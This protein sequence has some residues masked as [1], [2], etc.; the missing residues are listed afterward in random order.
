MKAHPALEGK[1]AGEPGSCDNAVIVWNNVHM[2]AVHDQL[3]TEANPI[4]R[5]DVKHLHPTRYEH[6]FIAVQAT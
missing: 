5:A 2:T 3:Q 6:S 1:C 4:L